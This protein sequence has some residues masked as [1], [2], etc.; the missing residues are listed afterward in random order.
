MIFVYIFAGLIVLLLLLA[1]LMP[2]GFNIEKS[3]VINNPVDAV[4][5]RVGD[6]NYY[7]KWNPWQQMDPSAKST[8]TGTPKTPGHRYAWEGKKVG[9]GS[10][11]LL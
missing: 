6:L 2:K 7:S 10:L 11:T 1:A 5:S 4:M 9:M 3:V 8:I